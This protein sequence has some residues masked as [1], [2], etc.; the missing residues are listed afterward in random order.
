MES[1]AIAR[2]RQA[3]RALWAYYGAAPAEHFLDLPSPNVR[4]RVQELGAGEPVLFIHGG[5][6]AGSTWA[7]LAAQLQA[8][9]CLVLDRPGCGLSAPLPA[10]GRPLQVVMVEVLLALLDRLEVPHVHLVV[11]SFGGWCGLMLARAHPE[12]V[13]RMVQ[14]G[15]P[16]FAPHM[17]VP[18]FMRLLTLPGAGALLSRAQR[19]PTTAGAKIS[20]RQMGHTAALRANAIP[21]VFWN[22]SAALGAFTGTFASEI[23]LI[24]TVVGLRGVRP[25]MTLTLDELRQVRTPTAFFWGDADTF[26]SIAVARHVVQAMPDAT[27]E[28]ISGGGHLPWL[29]DPD[30]AAR[31]TEAF[32]RA[33]P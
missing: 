28:V 27:L 6:N 33:G 15:C 16:G 19:L 23:G 11:S 26:G 3:E 20:F 12:R 14:H 2:Y 30:H 22:W 21:D 10:D 4:V 1:P 29:D 13:Q 17:R 9:R 7:P 31:Y 24:K 8:F 32:L 25:G 18:A 5:P